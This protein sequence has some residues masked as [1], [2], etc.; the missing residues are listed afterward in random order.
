VYT[1]GYK[2]KGEVME[3]D[4]MC[5]ICNKN[6]TEEEKEYDKLK[7]TYSYNYQIEYDY[8]QPKGKRSKYIYKCNNCFSVGNFLAE[9][10]EERRKLK[11]K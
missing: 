2:N 1:K 6:I 5:S 8:E 3:E 9:K 4:K 11:G 7:K 10:N